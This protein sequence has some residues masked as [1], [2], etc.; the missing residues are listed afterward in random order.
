MP[1][2]KLES[3]NEV[4][5]IIAKNLSESEKQAIIKELSQYETQIRDGIADQR[6]F[7]HE[8]VFTSEKA[9]FQKWASY[10]KQL[11]YLSVYKDPINTIS[12]YIKKQ[13][14][15]MNLP[16]DKKENLYRNVSRSLDA[17]YKEPQEIEGQNVSENTSAFL[18]IEESIVYFIAANCKAY[19]DIMSD[20]IGKFLKHLE[21]PQ[22]RA[23]FE[24]IVEWEEIAL[25]C[26]TIKQLVTPIK[27]T[28]K[29]FEKLDHQ[30]A[31]H[32]TLKNIEENFNM[33][34]S[35]D[36]FRNAMRL[37]V[38]TTPSYRNWAHR[39]GISP[40][41]HQRVRERDPDWP[42]KPVEQVIRDVLGSTMCPACKTDLITKRKYYDTPPDKIFVQYLFRE[43][44]FKIPEQYKNRGLNP[45][46]I[47]EKVWSKELKLV[48]L[49]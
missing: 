49:E 5:E 15:R 16:L 40:R 43:K 41:Q 39:F 6:S 27:E 7:I 29:N 14:G 24:R 47:A 38:L 12:K 13:I 19:F 10:L 28:Y 9:I 3:I 20:V 17:E 26:T 18:P 21:N 48:P 11:H 23:D 4:T 2:D 25:M 37:L 45:V 31:E 32:H 36:T 34:Q 1:T 44:K 33:R 42:D 35:V 8:M 46:Q 30:L 22:I